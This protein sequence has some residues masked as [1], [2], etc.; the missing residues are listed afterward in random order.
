MCCGIPE[1]CEFLECEIDLLWDCQESCQPRIKYIYVQLGLIEAAQ[2]FSRN[3]IDTMTRKASSQMQEKYTAFSTNK[4]DAERDASGRSCSWS[5]STSSQFFNRDS[6]EQGIGWTDYRH[7]YKSDM[8]NN[9][10]DLSCRHTFG[11]SFHK[12]RIEGNKTGEFTE[13]GN[14]ESNS[15]SLTYGGTDNLIPIFNLKWD[16]PIS[17]IGEAPFIAINRPIDDLDLFINPPTSGEQVC[18][19]LPDNENDPN[20]NNIPFCRNYN[21]DG[22]SNYGPYPSAGSGFNGHFRFSIAVPT[23]G[24][25]STEWSEGKNQRQYYHCSRSSTDDVHSRTNGSVDTDIG[26]TDANEDDNQTYSNENSTNLHLVRKYGILTRRAITENDGQ[27][28]SEGHGLGRAESESERNAKATAYTQQ[29]A[30]SEAKRHSESHYLRT[31]RAN[32]DMVLIKYGQIGRH[33]TSLWDR[34][35]THL[36][37]LERQFASKPYGSK[38]N[39]PREAQS[40]LPVRRSYQDLKRV[41]MRA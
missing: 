26:N 34:V 18:P 38:M 30:E 25:V 31:E 39:C 16:E 24:T 33:L 32:E 2:I 20:D 35:W 15:D 19:P 40:C 1:L 28:Q 29:R 37:L 17:R 8:L 41:I 5:A 14:G 3:K 6:E 4:S 13:R 23:I 27:E 10:F 36:R 11:Y 12:T 9:G 22:T 21:P 7:K